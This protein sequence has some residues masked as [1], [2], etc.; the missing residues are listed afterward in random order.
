MSYLC[1]LKYGIYIFLL[2]GI[3]FTF[4]NENKTSL[5]DLKKL[6]ELIKSGANVNAVDGEGNTP[7][8]VAVYKGSPRTVQFLLRHGADPSIRNKRGET[9]FE[10]N[11][12]LSLSSTRTALRKT[13]VI[14]DVFRMRSGAIFHE[15]TRY[16]HG[17]KKLRKMKKL[18]KRGDVNARDELGNTPLHKAIDDFF[19][20]SE[21]S[22][23]ALEA[24]VKA[25]ADVNARNYLEWE[26]PLHVAVFMG[27]PTTIEFLLRHGAD[28]NIRNKK[29][30]TPVEYN[31]RLSSSPTR[32]RQGLTLAINDAFKRFGDCR[33]TIS[34]I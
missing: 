7:L 19:F 12:R 16:L 4:A 13:E 10:Y 24:L 32:T 17:N 31:K 2:L 21:S 22:R 14:R 33:T 6:K 23:R 5:Q 8:H 3:G 1:S 29:G 26:T 20:L 28:P 11:D 15:I 9:P 34:K 25:G 27:V 18:I 30:D